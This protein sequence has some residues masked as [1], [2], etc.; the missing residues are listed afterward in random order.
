VR[1]TLERDGGGAVFHDPPQTNS[2]NNNNNKNK[3]NGS[4][5]SDDDA[6]AS[7]ASESCSKLADLTVTGDVADTGSGPASPTSA[8]MQRQI[9]RRS[10]VPKG[11]VTDYISLSVYSCSS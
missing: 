11:S 8:N 9:R 5:T 2:D 4:I 10:T 1:L 3:N 6:G 7:A